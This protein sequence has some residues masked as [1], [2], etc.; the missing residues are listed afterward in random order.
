M[1]PEEIHRIV[2]LLAK[3]WSD[4]RISRELV[5]S[6]R[7]VQRRVRDLMA[8]AGCG[9]RFALG[10][11]MGAHWARSRANGGGPG[12]TSRPGPPHRAVPVFHVERDISPR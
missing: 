3:G 7:T 8:A 6:T 5:L 11:A 4:E 2:E 9:S 10:F 12:R 1:R